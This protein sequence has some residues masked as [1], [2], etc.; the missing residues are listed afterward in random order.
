MAIVDAADSFA[1]NSPSGA[2]KDAMKAVSGAASDVVRLR[3]QK[4]SFQVRM[5]AS[6]AVEAIPGKDNGISR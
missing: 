2:E 3:L 6:S 5:I 1:Q 4:A